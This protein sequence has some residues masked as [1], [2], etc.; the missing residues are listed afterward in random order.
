MEN[1]N[2]K[3]QRTAYHEIGHAMAMYICCG[4]I[5]DI[6]YIEIA[7]NKEDF[8]LGR[9]VYL[10][11]IYSYANTPRFGT[12]AGFDYYFNKVCILLGGMVSARIMTGEKTYRNR[13]LQDA[14]SDEIAIDKIFQ[15]VSDDPNLTLI[16]CSLEL[17]R[18]VDVMHLKK[19]CLMFLE[20]AFS[21]RITEIQA[22]SDFLLEHGK[23]Y[24]S[25]FYNVLQGLKTAC[26]AS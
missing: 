22:L 18:T 4:D 19:T 13:P 1:K 6:E 23:M 8:T 9:N 15:R 3:Q 16:T 7:E 20:S 12:R 26:D 11:T 5:E 25:D 24:K 17:V 21:K 10:N 2:R 14:T